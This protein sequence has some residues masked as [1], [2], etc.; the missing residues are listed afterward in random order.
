MRNKI[1]IDP[2]QHRVSVI[3]M[4]CVILASCLP[5]VVQGAFAQ[6]HGFGL[7]L[8]IGE[9][10]GLS[11]KV[12]ISPVHALDFGLGWS[13]GGNWIGKQRGHDDRARRVHYHMD[14]LW[15]SFSAID[16]NQ[17]FPLYYGIGARLNAGAGYDESLALRGVIGIV[18]LPVDTVADFFFEIAPSFELLPESAFGL[19]ASLGVRYYF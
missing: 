13:V 17:R 2:P 4:C 14:H 11:A 9:P 5:F 8:M 16:A 18:W 12:W 7:G 6:D 10:T 3:R 1:V 15:H 19:D